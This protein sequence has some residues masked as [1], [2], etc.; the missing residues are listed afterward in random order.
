MLAAIWF[1]EGLL[2]LS[3][4]RSSLQAALSVAGHSRLN[5]I[6]VDR[7]RRSEQEVVLRDGRSRC[8][9]YGMGGPDATEKVVTMAGFAN[10]PESWRWL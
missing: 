5:A 2:S 6:E 4:A 10:G 7:S 8:D 3:R 9:C 1:S